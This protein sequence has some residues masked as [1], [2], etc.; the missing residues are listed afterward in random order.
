MGTEGTAGLLSLL[1]REGRLAKGVHLL[2]YWGEERDTWKGGRF[3]DGDR[4]Q[5]REGNRNR[6]K[7]GVR[8][9]GMGPRDRGKD[10]AEEHW[11]GQRKAGGRELDRDPR[12]K[13]K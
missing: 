11:V 9:I 3:R 13:A 8:N 1:I 10:W 6:F 7:D 12:I 2:T 4:S 5:Q